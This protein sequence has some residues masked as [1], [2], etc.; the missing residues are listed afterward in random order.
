MS[1]HVSRRKWANFLILSIITSILIFSGFGASIGNYSEDSDIDQKSNLY[2][3]EFAQKTPVNFIGEFDHT[4]R[5]EFT[6]SPEDFIWSKFGEF[7][8]L[9]LL[10][11]ELL[12]NP[13]EPVLPFKPV[14]IVLPSESNLDS[15]IITTQVKERI[16]LDEDYYILPG[17]EPRTVSDY[18]I[19]L[20]TISESEIASEFELDTEIY[21]SSKQ[22]PGNIIQKISE[23]EFNGLHLGH[24]GIIPVRYNPLERQI[25]IF[26]KINVNLAFPEV[27]TAQYESITLNEQDIKPIVQFL[28][29]SEDI[30]NF[31]EIGSNSRA[32]NS[33]QKSMNLPNRVVHYV[34]ITN[35]SNYYD[36]FLPLVQWKTKKG[37]PADIID[38]G[39]IRSA[40]SGNDT[41]EKIRNFIKDAKE[42][43]NTKYVLLGGDISVI[44]YRKAYGKVGTY[45]AIIRYLVIYI[46]Q[47]STVTGTRM[48]T[49]YMVK[50]LIM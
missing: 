45:P 6:F 2:F 8:T 1:Q 17:Q 7:D 13:G 39:W 27:E 5:M 41:Q 14:T 20:E 28:D 16:V 34:V 30:D 24:Y 10:E 40:Y 25:T 3:M 12:E 29:N 48:L 4:I 15:A 42:I 31:Y 9:I 22:Y 19:D 21:T 33:N 38:E 26:T 37:V 23:T 11:E 44:P 36:N 18:S 47:I 35:S 43:W 32:R 49:E 50:L 46:I